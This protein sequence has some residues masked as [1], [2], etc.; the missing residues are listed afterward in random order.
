[1]RRRKLEIRKPTTTAHRRPGK[2]VDDKSK[3]GG[4]TKR[5]KVWLPLGVRAPSSGGGTQG[6]QS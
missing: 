4:A 1:M 3:E 6:R 5:R 2:N